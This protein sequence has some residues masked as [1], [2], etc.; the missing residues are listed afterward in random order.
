MSAQSIP[1]GMDLSPAAQARH[2]MVLQIWSGL[3]GLAQRAL[4]KGLENSQVVVF[5]IMVD[6]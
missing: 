2:D 3:Q 5:C 6:S 1:V 4:S